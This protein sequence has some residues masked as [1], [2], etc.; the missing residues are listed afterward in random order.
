MNF[1]MSCGTA[2]KLGVQKCIKCN[3][4]FGSVKVESTNVKTVSPVKPKF[5]Y[6]EENFD[7]FGD[8]TID[9]SSVFGGI[10]SYLNDDTE[11]NH[12]IIDGKQIIQDL[13][14]KNNLNK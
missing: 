1:C 14:N 10:E 6:E 4:V 2:N 5:K 9:F 11:D 12:K 13:F 8:I 7:D 3:T